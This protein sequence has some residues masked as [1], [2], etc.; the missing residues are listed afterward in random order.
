VHIRVYGEHWP[1]HWSANLE[2]ITSDYDRGSDLP[3]SQ[4][5]TSQIYT[6]VP[7]EEVC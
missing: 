5:A 7:D 1:Q 6:F 3:W 4:I 2:I